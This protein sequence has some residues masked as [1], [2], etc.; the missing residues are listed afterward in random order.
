MLKNDSIA[1]LFISSGF[2]Q[3]VASTCLVCLGF[4]HTPCFNTSSK[5]YK[6][7]AIDVCCSEKCNCNSDLDYRALEYLS[8]FPYIPVNSKAN[9]KFKISH[10]DYNR[11]VDRANEIIDMYNEYSK[12]IYD[13]FNTIER[14]DNANEVT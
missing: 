10:L 13:K 4:K 8:E 7:Y 3:R 14:I 11:Y 6:N 5:Y 9:D 12:Y 1:F 2:W